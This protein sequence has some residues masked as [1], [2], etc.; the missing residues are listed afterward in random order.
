MRIAVWRTGHDIANV[1]GRTIIESSRDTILWHTQEDNFIRHVPGYDKHIAYGILRGTADVFRECDRLDKPWF[2]IDRGYFK[3]GHY[4]G[5][6]RVSLRGT[7]QTSGWP[8]PDYERLEQLNLDIK[9]WRGF[10]HSKPVLFIPPT[11]DAATFF[12]PDPVYGGRFS[13][14]DWLMSNRPI[15]PYVVRLKGDSIPINFS[16]YN[17]VLTF[18][19]SVGWQALAA[20]IPCVSDP[21]HSMV[22]AWFKDAN[23]TDNLS[24]LQEAERHKLFA[25]MAG[26]Q[27]TLEEMR[28]GK[29]WDLVQRLLSLSGTT[30][31][32]LPPPMLPPTPS[33]AAPSFQSQF[34][35]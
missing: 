28:A 31:E 4:D 21:K 29:L 20:G 3:P 35:T 11:N 6:Y 27:L 17:Y 14:D 10:D 12:M 25:C 8:E 33:P 1:V 16:D 34:A 19:S 30:P 32:S 5:Y 23:F 7:Q 13:L 26:L 9:P 24:D 22:G 2:N 15:G 18:N